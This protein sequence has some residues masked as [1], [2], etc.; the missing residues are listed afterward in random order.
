M[1]T[2]LINEICRL[3]K[4]HLSAEQNTILEG[5]LRKVFKNFNIPE[6]SEQ[7]SPQSYQTNTRLLNLFISAKKIEGCSAKTLKYYSST[8]LSMIN[9]LQKNVCDVKTDDIRFYLSNYQDIRNSS[10]ATLDNIRRIISSFY[11]WLE[12]ESYILKSPARRIHRRGIRKTA[13]SVQALPRPRY[14]RSFDF[15]GNPCRGTGQSQPL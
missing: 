1:E 7:L 13:R 15:N 8:L 2:T 3:M 6:Q 9:T 4:G 11:S 10:K 12:D 14:D 5:T